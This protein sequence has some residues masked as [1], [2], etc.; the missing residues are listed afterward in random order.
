VGALLKI[1]PGPAEGLPTL[2]GLLQHRESLGRQAALAVLR[3]YGPAAKAS[4]SEVLR[5]LKDRT[6]AVRAE[7]C[8]ALLAID[9]SA[10]SVERVLI[11]TLQDPEPQVRRQAAEL[12]GERVQTSARLQEA[13]IKAAMKDPSW[14]VRSAALLASARISGAIDLA[15]YY[16]A[17]MRDDHL[18]VRKSAANALFRMGPLAKAAVGDLIELSE[19][20]R[21]GIQ[22]EAIEALGAIGPD[23]AAALPAL[24]RMIEGDSPWLKQKAEQA[25]ARIRKSPEANLSEQ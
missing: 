19:R 8:Q 12:S 9:P 1:G 15:P 23:A 11:E 17:A 3:G 5:C 2:T 4:Q 16:A 22:A 21:Y 7:A 18:E 20:S 10:T 13:L 25:V 14:Q 6:E 24:K